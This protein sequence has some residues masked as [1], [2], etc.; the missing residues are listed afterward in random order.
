MEHLVKTFY[1]VVS[2]LDDP[3]ATLASVIALSEPT[4]AGSTPLTD[5]ERRRVLDFPEPDQESAAIAASSSLTKVELLRRGAESPQDLTDSE[6]DL[7]DHRYWAEPPRK[8]S[9]A[10]GAA[11]RA[12]GDDYDAVANRLEEIRAPLYEENE[13]RALGNVFYEWL[14]RSEAASRAE[15]DAEDEAALARAKPWVRRLWDE[16][17]TRSVWGYGVF[18]AP[19]IDKERLDDYWSRFDLVVQNAWSSVGCPPSLGLQWT[20]KNL[21]WPSHED[22]RAVCA[23]GDAPSETF[24]R[25]RDRF[26][27]IRDAEDDGRPVSRTLRNV[28]LVVDQDAVNSVLSRSGNVDDMWVWAVDPDYAPAP[29]TDSTTG[30]GEPGYR[31]FMQ[32]RIQQLA[33][34]FFNLRHF[35]EE[36]HPMSDLWAAAQRSRGGLFVSVDPVESGL[37]TMN[38]AIGTAL[39]TPRYI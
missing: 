22:G 12:L 24:Q 20:L 28:F 35:H 2:G 19:G 16:D 14:R 5:Q 11:H 21:A 36:E 7:L 8:A 3:D 39:G 9:K 1:R 15:K 6:I 26:V 18:C 17:E 13:A 34:D 23:L 4:V 32:V 30:A 10:Q 29:D 25:L 37:W 31:G 38:R 33:H 27:A